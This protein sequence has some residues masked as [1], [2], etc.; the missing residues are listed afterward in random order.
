MGTG[1]SAFTARAEA[2]QIRAVES[3][4][5]TPVPIGGGVPRGKDVDMFSREV[6]A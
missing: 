3:G 6:T 4:P 2:G 5:P 1:D